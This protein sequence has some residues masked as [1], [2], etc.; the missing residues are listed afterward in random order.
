L[1]VSKKGGGLIAA[2]GVLVKRGTSDVKDS[3]LPPLFLVVYIRLPNFSA[4][5]SRK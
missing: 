2:G 1:T 4:V 5:R 3:G